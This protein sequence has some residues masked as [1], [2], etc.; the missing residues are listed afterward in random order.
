MQVGV[1]RYFKE[2]PLQL[3]LGE[4][5]TSFLS[6]QTCG[7][8]LTQSSLSLC[9]PVFLSHPVKCCAQ[10]CQMH[11]LRSSRTETEIL[12]LSVF[13]W[14]SL[15]ILT[16]AVSV[17]WC[18]QNPGWLKQLFS[19]KEMF[20]CWKKTFSLILLKNRRLY[21]ASNCSCEMFLGCFLLIEAWGPL[22]LRW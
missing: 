8:L 16:R 18:G 3:S 10:L 19:T 12:P 21:I 2:W 13:R 15:N 7:Y 22:C 9:P 5:N 17:L 6:P 11:E 1:R 20:S 14:M 4:L